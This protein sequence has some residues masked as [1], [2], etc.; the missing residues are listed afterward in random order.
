MAGGWGGKVG[1][2]RETAIKI[3]K[4]N[5]HGKNLRNLA[6]EVHFST[7][8]EQPFSPIGCEETSNPCW[9]QG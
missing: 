3:S 2:V 4:P 1:K 6:L 8:A 7:D 9:F 5:R